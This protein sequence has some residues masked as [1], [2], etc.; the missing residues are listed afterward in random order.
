MHEEDL[1][2][3][4]LCEISLLQMLSQSLFFARLLYV[5]HV[6]HLIM[7][8]IAMSR[9]KTKGSLLCFLVSR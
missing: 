1:P 8:L 7:S 3:T 9:L 5:E 6:G 2:S 4:A